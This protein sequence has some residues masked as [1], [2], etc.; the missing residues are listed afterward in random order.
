MGDPQTPLYEA[1]ALRRV[2]PSGGEEVCALDGVTLSV[3]RGELVAVT[4]PNGC[5]KTTLLHILAFLDP[6]YT[7]ALRFQGRD[8]ATM[9][10]GERTRLRLGEVG[11]VFQRF[12]LLPW[13]NARDNAALPHWRLHGDKR[14]ARRKAETLLEQMELGHRSRQR[15]W[16][17]SGGEQQRVALARALVND[18]P[19]ILADEPTGNL[20]AATTQQITALFERLVDE[21]RTVVAVSHD[22]ELIAAATREVAL[23]YG[24]VVAAGEPS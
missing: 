16:R 8:V 13:L 17:L 6:A 14:A 11:L 15:V 3:A 20:D 1:A 21:G 18:P 7:G 24:R 9:P 10:V 4:G 2:F 22:R 12:H 5:G 23:R 19:V